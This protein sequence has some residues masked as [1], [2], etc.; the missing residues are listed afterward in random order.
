M[1]SCCAAG[2]PGCAM[3]MVW[4][5]SAESVQ[6]PGCSEGHHQRAHAR[7]YSYANA[8]VQKELSASE[9][10]AAAAFL[11]SPLASAVTG[12]VVYVDNGLNAMGLAPDSQALA[13]SAEPAPVT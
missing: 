1:F 11:L 6:V 13:Q 3:D 5:P 9:V 4:L 12:S 7:R 10:G 8:P 2:A